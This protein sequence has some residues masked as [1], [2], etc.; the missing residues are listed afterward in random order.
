M[1]LLATADR[2]LRAREVTIALGRKNPSRT[3]VQGVRRACNRLA[4]NGHLLVLKSG[5]FTGPTGA[6]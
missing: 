6:A 1:T 2:P 3:Q 5:E 4:E